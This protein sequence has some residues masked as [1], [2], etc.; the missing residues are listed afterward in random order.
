MNK[1]NYSEQVFKACESLANLSV[2]TLLTNLRDKVDPFYENQK[3]KITSK[4]NKLNASQ[5]NDKLISFPTY[6]KYNSS[7]IYD[8]YEE[9]LARKLRQ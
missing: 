1:A 5:N 7:I 2:D 6:N 8:E 3:N 4:P 9:N